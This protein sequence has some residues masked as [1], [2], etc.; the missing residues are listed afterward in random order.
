MSKALATKNVAA[1]LLG[2]ALVVTFAFAFAA[3]AK[4]DTL[5]DLQAQ[6]Q[7]LLAQIATLQGGSSSSSSGSMMTGSGCHTF[8]QNLKVGATGGEVMWVQQFLNGHGFQVAASGAGSPGNETSHFG[9]ATKAAVIKFQNANASTILT[10]VGL[11]AGTGNWLAATRAAANAMCAGG[12]TT[13]GTTTGGTTAGGSLMISAGTQPANSLA[14]AGASRVP[15]TTFML[16]NT[17]NAAVTVSGVTVQRTGLANDNVFS[18]VVLVDSNGLQVGVSHTFDSNHMTTVGDTMTI[19]PGQSVT[20]TVAGNMVAQG[21]AIANASGGQV[22]SIAVTGVNVSSGTV[23]GALPITGAMQT[24]NSTL[25]TGAVTVSSS[26][27]DPN[28]STIKHIGDTGIKFSGVR[29]T[30]GSA[31]DVK[32]YSIRWRTNGN[33]SPGDLAN[34]M[35]VVNGTSY[36]SIVSADGRYYTSTF[37]GG[38]LLQKGNSVDVY[39]QGDIVGTN[40]AGRSAE[41]DIDKTYDVYF[42]GQTYGYGIS[43][44]AASGGTYATSQPHGTGYDTTK[45]PWFSGSTVTINGGQVTSIQN[46]TAVVSQNVAVNVPNQVLGGFQTNFLGEPVTVQGLTITV[47]TST[48]AGISYV[49]LTLVSIVDENGAVVAGPMD[50]TAGSANLAFTNSMTFPT[51]AH[52]YTIKG[53]LSSMF[54]NGDSIVLSTTPNGWTSPQGQTTGNSVDLSGLSSP[55]SFNTMTVRSSTLAIAAGSNPSAQ[56]IV[57][58]GQN[59]VLATIQLDA[60]QSGE[61]LRLSSI[62]VN[63][64]T[65]TGSPNTKLNTCQIW[66]GTTALNTGSNVVNSVNANASTPAVGG[67]TTFTLDNSLTITKGTVKNLTVSCNLSSNA[68]TNDQFKV[69]VLTKPTVTGVQSGN[70]LTTNMTLTNSYSGIMTVSGGAAVTAVVDSSSP[71]YNV[72]A[73]G[74]TQVTVGVI[75]LRA[76][77]EN[78]NLTKIGLNA[79]TGSYGSGSTGSGGAASASGDIMTV[80][81]YNSSGTQIGSATFLSGQN[82][83]TTTLSTPLVLTRDQ[84]TLVTIKADLANIGVS[85]SGGIGNLVKVDPL[86]FEGTGANSGTTIRGGATGTTGGVRLFKSY[87]TLSLDTLSSSGVADGRLIHFK[88][89]SSSGGPIGINQ[90]SFNISSTSATVTNVG[91]YAYNDSSYSNPISGQGSGGQIGATLATVPGNFT[92]TP[93]TNPVQVNGTVYFELKGT[94]SGSGTSYNVVTKL[95][96]DS[97][98]SMS[99]ASSVYNVA[100]ASTLTATSSLIWSGNSTSTSAASDIDWSNGFTLPGLPSSGLIQNRTN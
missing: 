72:A 9:P 6:V 93:T 13:G 39:V 89:T 14:P 45:Q 99:N 62:P 27:F 98:M 79:G 23:G 58:G 46:A 25:T 3:P 33:N 57:K 41:F 17:S 68:T 10:P 100:N 78:V 77:N 66:D 50:M 47:S 44:S 91:L 67:D 37:P 38:I 49:P 71:S 61:D 63:V 84:D 24:F 90:F 4:A 70:T 82:T 87:P 88:V 36:P 16:T 51:G 7:A 5:T 52:T 11:T 1:V 8:T 42:V 75:K 43:L 80:W 22:A 54:N 20:L 40:A 30:A 76:S 31:E 94:V 95:S 60:S 59:I 48:V 64:V 96:G 35:T 28:G 15:F 56:N 26:S 53:K 34:V 73:A 86:N 32:F 18:G 55:I 81:L 65:I 69:G 12:S 97:T 92:L 29:F 2:V 74:T 83:A 19:N 21:S 85:S